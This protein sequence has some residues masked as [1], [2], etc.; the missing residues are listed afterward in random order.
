MVGGITHQP[1]LVGHIYNIASLDKRSAPHM[2]SANSFLEN[3]K[4]TRLS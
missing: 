3:L 4:L 1:L 2:A